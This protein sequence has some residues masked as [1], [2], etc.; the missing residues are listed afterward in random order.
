MSLDGCVCMC[1]GKGYRRH[2]LLYSPAFAKIREGMGQITPS[3]M[4]KRA[5]GG[6][7][8]VRVS[9]LAELDTSQTLGHVRTPTP[10]RAREFTA[11]PIRVDGE[12]ESFQSASESPSRLPEGL[13]AESPLISGNS[14]S[15]NVMAE[16]RTSDMA[17]PTK[18]SPP[19]S[20][21]SGGKEVRLHT[22][23]M[24]RVIE[25]VVEKVVTVEVPGP[26]R[27]VEVERLVIKEV[28]CQRKR[29]VPVDTPSMNSFHTPSTTN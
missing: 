19:A 10:N 18:V 25:K 24:T 6:T 7:V 27:I 1:T 15:S 12:N 8:P 3:S 9:P 2:S 29:N 14:C 16:M 13:S 5:T 21:S 23:I 4:I 28:R 20:Q 26:E 11:S 17:A 22:D